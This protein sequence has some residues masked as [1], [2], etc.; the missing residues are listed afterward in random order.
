MFTQRVTLTNQDA[1]TISATQLHKLGTVAETADGRCYRYSQAG[2]VDLAAGK[3]NTTVAKV[4]NH[5]NQAVAA[6]A[7]VGA[8]SVSITLG[9]TATTIGQYDGGYLVINDSAGVGCAYLIAG[10]PVIA[11]SGTGTIQLAEGI[12]TALTTS[13]KYSLVPN[14]WAGSIVSAAAA[15]LFVNGTNNVLVTAANYYWSQTGGIASVLSD[16]I[17]GK[18]SDAI[19]SASVNGAAVV[20]GTSAVTQRVGVAPEA[21]VDTKYY[22]LF[23]TLE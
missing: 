7:A 12:A 5:T 15:A 4:T 11:L 6:A 3:L 17:I 13:S 9:A 10:T 2:A 18:G 8:R 23:L 14:P 21:T 22:A 20:E 16:G 19:V 1:R